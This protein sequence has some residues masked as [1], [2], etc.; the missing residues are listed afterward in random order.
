MRYDEINR[1]ALDGISVVFL[2]QNSD[3]MYGRA[4]SSPQIAAYLGAGAKSSLGKFF[5]F[6]K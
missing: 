6:F 3:Q 1:W 4:S 2:L 5:F